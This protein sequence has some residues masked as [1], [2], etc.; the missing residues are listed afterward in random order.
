MVR[1]GTKAVI[2]DMKDWCQLKGFGEIYVI[3]V[4]REKEESRM[5]SKYEQWS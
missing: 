1:V 4:L 2:I 5:N 3:R